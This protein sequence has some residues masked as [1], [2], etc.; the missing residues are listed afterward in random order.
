ML[1]VQR[2]PAMVF[3]HPLPVEHRPKV[4][5]TLHVTRMIDGFKAA[6][7]EVEVVAG[8]S[9]E[10][11]RSM[12]RI[13]REVTS[14]RVFDFVYAESSTAPT[15]LNDPNHLPLHPFA[16]WG[17]L[18]FLQRQGLPVGLFYPD[19]H[20]RF[21]FYRT[22]VHP[23]K[24]RLAEVFYRFDLWWYQRALD[25]LFLPSSRM[26]L[27]VPGWEQSDRVIGLA[28]GGDIEPFENTH[29]AG[30]L[31]LFYV[32]SITPPLYDISELV[33]AVLAVPNVFLTVCCPLGEATLASSFQCDRVT[34]IHQH[35]D[36]LRE[37]YR[38]SDVAC[39]VY[40]PEPYREFA[41]PVKMFEAIGFG[42]PVL[43]SNGTT[44][45]AFIDATGTGWVVDDNTLVPTLAR[46]A[47]D[48]GLV[49]T[50][51][52]AVVAHQSKH[53]WESRARFVADSLMAP[54]DK[55]PPS[56]TEPSTS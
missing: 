29:R 26:R 25:I 11:V 21:P 19:V 35:G 28:P 49:A 53:T 39:L 55:R 24:R 8:Y 32:G 30:Q 56:P 54:P 14:G 41:M 6:G 17:F 48:S 44:A 2:S 15:A 9:S 46:L 20:W 45:A 34:V 12:K 13:R 5:S 27:S 42:R 37:Q 18:R 16:D 47:A 38:M 7:Y 1:D 52:D 51:Y 43:A 40:P 36:A 10:R 3:H 33:R 50:R 23:V 31:H 4:G 22:A